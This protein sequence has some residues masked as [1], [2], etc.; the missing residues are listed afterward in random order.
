MTAEPLLSARVSRRRVLQ[1]LAALWGTVL[2]PRWARADTARAQWNNWSG[3]QRAEPRDL[4][5]PPT[6]A[7]LIRAVATATDGVRAVGGSHSFSPVVPTSGRIISLEALTG[8]VRH[9]AE[10]QTATLWGGTRLFATGPLL[11][12]IGQALVNEPDINLQSLAGAISTATHGTGLELQCLSGYVRGLRL[13]TAGGQIVECSPQHDPDVFEAAR[14]SVGSLGVISQVTLQNRAS[15]RLEETTQVASVKRAYEIMER[16][17]TRNRHI[18]FFAFPYGGRAVIKRL[19]ETTADVTPTEVP[20]F[21]ENELLE[22]A[23]DLS[24]RRPWLTGTL[25]R[26]VGFFVSESRRVDESFR[27]FPA[28]RTVRFNEMEYTVP[29][30]QGLACLE[31]VMEIMRKLDPPVF[32]PIEFRYTG[33]DE[34]WLSP[35]YRQPGASISVHQYY[36]QDYEPLF[37]A[38]EPVFRKYRGRPHWGKLHTLTHRELRELYPKFGDFLRVR[39]RLDPRGKFLNAHLRSLFGEERRA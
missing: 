32:F 38:V 8:L 22:W 4:L 36:K 5:F 21:D 9:D 16:E 28:P 12:P 24:R 13:V 17:K 25:Q 37:Q 27:I 15:Y 19:N 33:A 29:A 7:D 34:S 20:R 39:K 3:N 18:E 30:D 11:Q 14:V 10:A 23:A 35:F 6:E 2:I 1:G 26:L 31:E